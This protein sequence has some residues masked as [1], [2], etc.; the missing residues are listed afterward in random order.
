MDAQFERGLYIGNLASNILG[1]LLNPSY[2]VVGNS[3]MTKSMK[4]C[5]IIES[6]TTINTEGSLHH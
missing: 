5:T 3:L 2:L 6:T 1:N 4:I